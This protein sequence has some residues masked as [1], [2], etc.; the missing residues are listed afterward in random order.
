MPMPPLMHGALAA[1][2]GFLAA[3]VACAKVA[4]AN[5][6]ST[7]VAISVRNDVMVVLQSGFCMHLSADRGSDR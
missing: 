5:V 7:A 3:S 1:G 4:V 6:A 2:P